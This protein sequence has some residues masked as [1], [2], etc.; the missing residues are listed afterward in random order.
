MG[1]PGLLGQ[2]LYHDVSRRSDRLVGIEFAGLFDTVEAYG[3]PIEEMRDAINWAIWPIKFHDHKLSGIVRR[4][5]HAL[6]LD[7]ERQ[8]FHPVRFDVSD[9]QPSARIREVWF[10]GVHSDVGGGYPDGALSLVPLNW[11]LSE[12]DDALA[13]QTA[14]R[15]HVRDGLSALARMHDSRRGTGVFYRYAP[16]EIGMGP[17]TG[18]APVVHHAVIEK[19]AFGEE[20][21]APH[22]LPA[23]A[24][25]LMPDGT[26]VPIA[27]FG[28]AMP[29]GLH[30]LSFSGP[31]M[32]NAPAQVV[33]ERALHLIGAPDL[34]FVD[35][36]RDGVWLRR[37]AYFGLLVCL[38]F[39][40]SLPLTSEPI[41][42]WTGVSARAGLDRQGRVVQ[43]NGGLFSA[44]QELATAVAGIVP[45]YARPW[46][47]AGVRQPIVAA[48]ALLLVVFFLRA[49][50]RLRDRIADDA[51]CAW[52]ASKQKEVPRRGI[53]TWLAER[54][55]SNGG[56][57]RRSRLVYWPVFAS[58]LVV[59]VLGTFLL[60]NRLAL[61]F[62]TG[63]GDLCRWDQTQTPRRP[64]VG[65]PEDAIGFTTSN[66]CWDTGLFVEK[67]FAYEIVL[68]VTAPYMDGP[69]LADVAG[70]NDPSWHHLLGTPFKR[71][72]DEAYF[73]PIGRI[74]Q[75]G[76]TEWPIRSDE[77][78][79]PLELGDEA[80]AAD[81]APSDACGPAVPTA[82]VPA[83]QQKLG[84][85]TRLR[86][87]FTAQESGELFLYVNDAMFGSGL[88]AWFATIPR[89]DCFYANNSGAAKVTVTLLP[90]PDPT[91]ER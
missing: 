31:D 89:R 76:R 82:D 62:A 29:A 56:S 44:L 90:K 24:T 21:Y 8:T 87:R 12:L 28:A 68:Q 34:N 3:V 49:N 84:I 38:L 43:L 46:V 1:V 61:S 86:S 69:K 25:V 74:G 22:S 51:R 41:A 19:I 58:T 91:G 79:E 20:L 75:T 52:F 13:F 15:Q 88:L 78:L 81:G 40:L 9:E 17:E 14:W 33:A 60:L 72:W 71:W 35:L 11:M 39:V 83:L 63:Y 7:D 73:Q 26:H 54:L 53:A 55:R 57:A 42:R 10:A 45:G 59:A 27:G 37:K 50:G 23:A 85:R 30:K 36:V 6:S 18:G 47:D 67:G 5:R 66:P 16:R 64:R 80:V 77:G 32:R 2:E 70:F 65:V 4:A 48:A